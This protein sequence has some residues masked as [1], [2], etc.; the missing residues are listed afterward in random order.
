MS[1]SALF[2]IDDILCRVRSTCLTFA[3]NIKFIISKGDK[4]IC[5]SIP[6]CNNFLIV[7]VHVPLCLSWFFFISCD[8]LPNDIDASRL[9]HRTILDIIYSAIKSGIFCNLTVKIITIFIVADRSLKL[10]YEKFLTLIRT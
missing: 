10:I 7:N 5:A 6:A 3:V 9:N 4:N 8:Y 2:I 1:F